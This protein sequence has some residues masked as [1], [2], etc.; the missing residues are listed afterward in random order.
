VETL[1]AELLL[2]LWPLW[3]LCAEAVVLLPL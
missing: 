2:K 1:W 3:L